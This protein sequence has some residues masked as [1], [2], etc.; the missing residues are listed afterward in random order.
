M[1]KP[2]N[3]FLNIKSIQG[4]TGLSYLTIYRMFTEGKI[5]GAFQLQ[6]RWLVSQDDWVTYIEGLKNA[7]Q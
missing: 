7:R 2:Q 4:Q 5:K 3:G 1:S 6:K